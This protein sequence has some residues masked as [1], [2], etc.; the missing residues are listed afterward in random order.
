[1]RATRR[2]SRSRYREC[3]CQAL[4]RAR[5]C[6]RRPPQCAPTSTCGCPSRNAQARIRETSSKRSCSS[7]DLVLAEILFGYAKPGN[8]LASNRSLLLIPWQETIR[9]FPPYSRF[10][11][12]AL[13]I[14]SGDMREAIE[15]VRDA[16]AGAGRG[17]AGAF[18]LTRGA[19][20]VGV[21]HGKC[22]YSKRATLIFSAAVFLRIFSRFRSI[23]ATPKPY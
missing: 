10:R 2:R 16:T 7:Q 3:A 8:C 9:P 5:Q 23:S 4:L 1:M 13:L 21:Y 18:A 22:R 6:A 19:F 12:Q 15:R 20:C 17:F 14:A 11:P